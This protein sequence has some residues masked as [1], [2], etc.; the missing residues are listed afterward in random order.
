MDLEINC[1]D[2]IIAPKGMVQAGFAPQDN[3]TGGKSPNEN[4]AKFPQKIS[5]FGITYLDKI[6]S[7]KALL[8]A[9]FDPPKQCF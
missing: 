2:E 4:S 7:P 9:G 3:N 5:E 8:Q 1:L 6:L